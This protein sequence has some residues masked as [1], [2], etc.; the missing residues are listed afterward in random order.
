MKYR[1]FCITLRTR[2]GINS[3]LKN[4]FDCWIKKQEF[5]AYVFEKEGSEEHI[6]GQIWFNDP[7]TRGNVKKPCDAMIRKYYEPDDY[8]LSIAVVVRIGYNDEFIEEYCKKENTLIYN[9]IPPDVDREKY[10]PSEE[11][12]ELAQAKVHSK[13][14]WL[15]ELTVLWNQ[16][17]TESEKSHINDYSIASFLGRICLMDLWSIKKDFKI[18]LEERN[19]L[20]IWLSKD[21]C[22]SLFLTK[23]MIKIKSD[24]EILKNEIF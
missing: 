16:H 10:Y 2:V 8:K 11:E 17:A 18:R 9:K 24:L 5:G 21:N 1:S 6:H 14:L 3:G 22:E 13:N 19:I 12:Q 7:R 4:A 15:M 20:K 23:E